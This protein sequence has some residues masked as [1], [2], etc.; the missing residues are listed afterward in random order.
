[1]VNNT[2]G[3]TINLPDNDYDTAFDNARI[4]MDSAWRNTSNV[5]G[6][7]PGGDYTDDVWVRDT[8]EWCSWFRYNYWGSMNEQQVKDASRLSFKSFLTKVGMYGVRGLGTQSIVHSGS[9]GG[10]T[11]YSRYENEMI[12][13]H[14]WQPIIMAW[15]YYQEYNDTKFLSETCGDSTCYIKMRDSIDYLTIDRDTN[16]NNVTEA[17]ENYDWGDS[18]DDTQLRVVVDKSYDTIGRKRALEAMCVFADKAGDASNRSKY[19]VM[20]NTTAA[21]INDVLWSE[22]SNSYQYNKY[23]NGTEWTTSHNSTKGLVTDFWAIYFGV[24]NNETR[25]RNIIDSWKAIKN[26]SY[27]DSLGFPI[28]NS[29]VCPVFVSKADGCSEGVKSKGRHQDHGSWIWYDHD[30]VRVLLDRHD[31]YAWYLYDRIVKTPEFG[32]A[33]ASYEYLCLDGSAGCNGYIPSTGYQATTT[34]FGRNVVRHIFGIQ[35][36]T[37]GYG[38]IWIRPFF[39][40]G[41][42]TAEI[43]TSTSRGYIHLTYARISDNAYG[44]YINSSITGSTAYYELPV[45]E[46]WNNSAYVLK[47]GTSFL[48]IRYKNISDNGL[49]V[50]FSSEIGIHYYEVGNNSY[51]AGIMSGIKRIASSERRRI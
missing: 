25:V 30:A 24:V 12:I 11:S 19:C 6:C 29:S 28:L 8:S 45:P 43:N 42:K 50:A 46:S 36:K 40:H 35:P 13:D 1:M 47:D 15:D 3:T 38:E 20:A 27:P 32:I 39:K 41:W 16:K 4:I 5:T 23:L 7:V 34:G 37:P 10:S 2:S 9:R 49:V 17:I 22:D 48:D 51:V 33:R 21:A 18:V 44:Y 31:P 14:V 26:N